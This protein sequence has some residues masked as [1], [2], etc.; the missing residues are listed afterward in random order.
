MLVGL[1]STSPAMSQVN[2]PAYR[3]VEMFFDR[4]VEP[5]LQER[6][7]VTEGLTELDDPG[8]LSSTTPKPDGSIWVAPDAHVS[9]HAFNFK[10]RNQTGCVVRWHSD[11]AGERAIHGQ[12]VIEQFDKWADTQIAAER[13]HEVQQCGDRANKFSRLLESRDNRKI[14]LRILISTIAEI[15]FVFL[16]AGKGNAGTASPCK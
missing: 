12:F 3:M 7:I 1:I 8:F 10:T 6:P 13:F 14:P 9:M 16:V 5:L 2:L 4:C 11:A 15:D